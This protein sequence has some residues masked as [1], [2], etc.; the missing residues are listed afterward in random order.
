MRLKQP[1]VHEWCSLKARL[2]RTQVWLKQPLVDV[3]AIS[4]RHDVVEALAADTE[5]RDRLRDQSLRGAPVV[6]LVFKS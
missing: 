4:E 1:S 5:L 6:P 3:A 2:G